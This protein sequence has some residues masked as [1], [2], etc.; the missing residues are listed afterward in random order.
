MAKAKPAT[1][2][3]Q[4]WRQIEPLVRPRVRSSFERHRTEHKEKLRELVEQNCDPDAQVQKVRIL[5]PAVDYFIH[6]CSELCEEIYLICEETREQ[7]KIEKSPQSEDAI[8]EKAIQ[9]KIQA[10]QTLAADDLEILAPALADPNW[11]EYGTP[12]LHRLNRGLRMVERE[13]QEKLGV[14]LRTDSGPETDSPEQPSGALLPSPI[15]ASRRNPTSLRQVLQK[16]A[17][18]ATA[19]FNRVASQAHE[20]TPSGSEVWG[21]VSPEEQDRVGELSSKIG[22]TV[23]AISSAVRSSPLVGDAGQ[24]KLGAAMDKMVDALKFREL[25]HRDPQVWS[26]EERILGFTKERDE[27]CPITIARAR[28]VFM[29]NSSKVA[30]FLDLLSELPAQEQTKMPSRSRKKGKKRSTRKRNPEVARRRTFIK[31]CLLARNRRPSNWT[32]C[33]LLDE[34]GVG[35]PPSLSVYKNWTD[36]RETEPDAVDKQIDSDIRRA[37]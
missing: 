19:Y 11:D 25:E 32:I 10:M 3:D 8:F 21:L 36:A 15:A 9:P 17:G 6:A 33:K 1:T 31:N 30:G 7:A 5:I 16:I 28:Y 13:W 24:A 23:A 18:E 34:E 37:K 27:E 29:D 2:T 22:Q 12:D 35:L 20:E 26:D 4:I 14:E